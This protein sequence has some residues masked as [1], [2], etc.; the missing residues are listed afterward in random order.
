M[1]PPTL[2]GRAGAA[3][4]AGSPGGLADGLAAWGPAAA[5]WLKKTGETD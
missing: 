1:T 5:R 3:F 4:A 2:P